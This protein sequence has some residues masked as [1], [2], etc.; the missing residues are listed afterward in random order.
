MKIVLKE[1]IKQFV[2]IDPFTKEF[3]CGSGYLHPNL[4]FAKTW[5]QISSAKGART[6]YVNDCIKGYYSYLSDRC[7]IPK[8]L[9]IK[10]LVLSEY[11]LNDR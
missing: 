4:M 1:P 9:E 10:R 7:V 2:L 3:Y 6:R 11:E 8:H 5:D